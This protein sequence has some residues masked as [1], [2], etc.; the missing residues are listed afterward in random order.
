[1][2]EI[3]KCPK[4]SCNGK[5][6]PLQYGIEF[7]CD[8]CDLEGIQDVRGIIAEQQAEIE[9]YKKKVKENE[10]IA[11]N[12]FDALERSEKE[13]EKYKQGIKDIRSGVEKMKNECGKESK[14]YKAYDEVLELINNI[15]KESE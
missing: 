2:S 1:M 10:R 13:T 5:I 3:A 6:I 9:K 4:K 12:W 15:A 8:T 11:E 14:Y 7:K